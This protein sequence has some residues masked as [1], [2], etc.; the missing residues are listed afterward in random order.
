MKVKKVSAEYITDKL[1][2]LEGKMSFQLESRG[3][4]TKEKKEMKEKKEERLRTVE[5]VSH[6]ASDEYEEF[7]SDEEK[8]TEMDELKK[9]MM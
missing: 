1:R 6:D 2:K 9:R 8:I 7:H 5:I 3:D 4:E